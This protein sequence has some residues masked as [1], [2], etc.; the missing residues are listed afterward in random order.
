[1]V[2]FNVLNPVFATVYPHVLYLT[3]QS[4]Y[5]SLLD[6]QRGQYIN[7]TYGMGFLGASYEPPSIELYTHYSLSTYFFIFCSLVA[8]HVLTIFIIDKIWVKNIP[9]S[10]NLLERILH[11]IQK[12]NFPFPFVNWHNGDG[13]CHEHMKRKSAAQTEVLISTGI[14]LVFNMILLFPL[15]ILCMIFSCLNVSINVN[16]YKSW[17]CR[18]RN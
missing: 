18:S 15:A 5:Q 12:S 8:I 4:S 17:I 1:M 3:N 7:Y 6:I 14:N 16:S 9:Q 11:S 10:A 2:D 13:G